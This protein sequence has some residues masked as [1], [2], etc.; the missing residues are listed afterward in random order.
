LKGIE[1]SFQV[2]PLFL[3]SF[4]FWASCITFWNFLKIPS[5][6]SLRGNQRRIFSTIAVRNSLL[7]TSLIMYCTC[8]VHAYGGWFLMDL[9]FTH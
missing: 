8:G 3:K 6:L 7:Q 9:D 1:T 4:H 2:V 5:G